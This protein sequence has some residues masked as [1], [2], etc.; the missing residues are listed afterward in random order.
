VQLQSGTF[1]L[2]AIASGA[3]YE[4][5]VSANV[6][7]TTGNVANTATI[8]APAGTSDPAPANNTATE[9]TR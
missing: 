2:P 6:T 7:A 9:Q 1:T 8:Q 3:F 5:T 4:I